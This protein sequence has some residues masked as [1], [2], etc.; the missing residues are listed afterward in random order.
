MKKNKFPFAFGLFLALLVAFAPMTV[1]QIWLGDPLFDSIFSPSLSEL[2]VARAGR[3]MPLSSAASDVLKSIGGRNS[4]K[5]SK[6]KISASKWLWKINAKPSEQSA[7]KIFRTDNKDLQVLLK[8][9]GRNYSY[10]DFADNYERLWKESEGNSKYADACANAINS[11]LE[12]AGA[13]NAFAVKFGNEIGALQSLKN[14]NESVKNATD[15]L[16]NARKEK[17]DADHSKL[18]P[19]NEYLKFL[20]RNAEYESTDTSIRVVPAKE[21]TFKSVIGAMLDRNLSSEEAD[22]LASYAKIHGA[23]A[24]NNVSEAKLGLSELNEKLSKIDKINLIKVKFENIVNSLDPFFGGFIL[25]GLSILFFVL[26]M[27]WRRR[28]RSLVV[29]ATILLLAGVGEHF[30]GILARMYIQS[31]P[32]VTNMYSSVVF[33]GGCSALV[34]LGAFLKRRATILALSASVVGFFSLLVALNLPHSGDTMGMMRAVLN[35]N[36]WLT[37]HVVTI[38]VGYCG[39]F[40]GGFIAAFRLIANLFSKE[41]FGILTADTARYVYSILCFSLVFSFA[42]TMLGG[43]WADMS[44][45]R[46]WGW[47]PKENGA[48]MVVLWTAASIHLKAM[49]LFPDRIFLAMAVFGNIVGAWAWFG[50]NLMGIGLHSYGFVEGGWLWFGAFV[51]S[52]YVICQLGFYKYS[53]KKGL[54]KTEIKDIKV[55]LK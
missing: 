49:R 24:E 37:I 26:S 42:G 15:E 31:R 50:V 46:F 40:L 10:N 3:Q 12:Y 6:G 20:R 5:T 52:Q 16:N 30:F 17:R 33:A 53:D 23:I 55:D 7:E 29:V 45:G 11:G 36:F 1:W 19:A 4:A 32:P 13:S 18:I 44:W 8:A 14:W 35:S 47:D 9:E 22:I 27:F 43:I 48:L 51:V 2:P 21:G 28:E 39:L 41:N 25:Y 54:N 38:M 34:G